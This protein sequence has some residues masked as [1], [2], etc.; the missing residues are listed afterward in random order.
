MT[1]SRRGL[2]RKFIVRREDPEAQARHEHCWHFV[3]DLE[4][5]PHAAAA[6]R[7]YAASVLDENPDL[8]VDL[9]MRIRGRYGSAAGGA[10]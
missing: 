9:L 8:A 1:G 7:A 6:M 2:H 3:L 5:D 4:H 10:S